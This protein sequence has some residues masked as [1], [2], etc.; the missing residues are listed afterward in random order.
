MFA[1]A[2]LCWVTDRRSLAG[3]VIGL[4]TLIKPHYGLI[5]V[6]GILRREWS[7]LAVGSGTIAFGLAWSLYV[8]EWA[9][10]VDYLRFLSYISQRGEAYFP[11]HS[12]NG[13]LNRLMS[14]A[15]PV[16]YN[17]LTW[18]DGEFPPF[19]WWVYVGTLG[20]SVLIL[21]V[22]LVRRRVRMTRT[23]RSTCARSLLPARSRADRLEHHYGILLPVYAVLFAHFVHDRR[24]LVWLAVSYVLASNYFAVAQMAANTPF[25]PAQ[26]YLLFG[27]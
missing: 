1:L 22:G 24:R 26:S 11:N 25:N 17:N 13:L 12:V 6:W 9:N 10:H 2:L 19:N 23:V 8:F 21:A 27:A 18:R 20:S 5:F 15:D 7:F 4:I 3:F 14:L 16:R